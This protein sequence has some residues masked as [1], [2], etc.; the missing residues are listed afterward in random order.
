MKQFCIKDASIRM[1][2]IQ[3]V[4]LEGLKERFLKI[5]SSFLRFFFSKLNFGNKCFF[6]TCSVSSPIAI[7]KAKKTSAI[8]CCCLAF[9]IARCVFLFRASVSILTKFPTVTFLLKSFLYINKRCQ[10]DMNPLK[11]NRERKRLSRY[12]FCIHF[13]ITRNNSDTSNKK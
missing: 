4:K 3:E 11:L 12:E 10:C 5:Y 7:L 13:E 1:F 9:K 8:S 6:T 2:L